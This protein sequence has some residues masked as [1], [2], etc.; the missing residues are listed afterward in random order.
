MIRNAETSNESSPPESFPFL[1]QL[2][3]PLRVGGIDYLNSR[4][5]V[6]GF[7]EGLDRRGAGLA[8]LQAHLEQY[9]RQEERL[10]RSLA[11]TSS[12]K[13]LFELL[14]EAAHHDEQVT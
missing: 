11:K 9:E 14:E 3:R 5:L 13:D 10:D 12:S 8:A 7:S 2:G 4:P 1:E 6:E